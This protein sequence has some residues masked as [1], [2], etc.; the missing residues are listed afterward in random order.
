MAE[1]THEVDGG[2]PDSPFRSQKGRFN[3]LAAECRRVGL[4]LEEL[5]DDLERIRH[6][7]QDRKMDEALEYMHR[8]RLDLVARILF[9]A[10]DAA[11]TTR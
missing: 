9:E 7:V 1:T 3:R 8:I 2:A 6:L 5:P 10:S 11:R 4:P